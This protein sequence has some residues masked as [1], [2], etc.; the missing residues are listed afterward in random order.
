MGKP[1]EIW[2]E[3]EKLYKLMK[4]IHATEKASYRLGYR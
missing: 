3:E 1:P 4:Q 2:I